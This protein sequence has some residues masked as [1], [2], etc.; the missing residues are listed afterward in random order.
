MNLAHRYILSITD[1]KEHKKL[2]ERLI[3]RI[4]KAEVRIDE[5]GIPIPE[6]WTEDDDS[7]T[8]AMATMLSMKQWGRMR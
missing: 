1:P 5:R 3:G 6:W 8:G 7:E 2:N 4:V